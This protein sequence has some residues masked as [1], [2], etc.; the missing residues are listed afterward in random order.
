M[1]A[2]SLRTKI[3]LN[4]ILVFIVVLAL[5]FLVELFGIPFT[6]IDGEYQELTYAFLEN[7][8]L[9][10][11]LKKARLQE[12]LGERKGDLKVISES[13]ELKLGIGEIQRSV[14]KYKQQGWEEEQIWSTIQNNV[15]IQNL[16]QHLSL[17]INAYGFYERIHIID[18]GSRT[19]LASSDIDE[20]G[21]DVSHLDYIEPTLPFRDVFIHIEK[22]EA[23]GGVDL[24]MA[25]SVEIDDS[26][27]S[28]RDKLS[29]ILIMYI[30]SRN[31]IEPML[32]TGGGLGETG[33]V[34]LVNQEVKV[35]HR[36]K[37][38][39]ADGSAAE[40]LEFQIAAEPASFA[41]DGNEGIAMTED[42][43]QIPVL[44]AY[45]YIPLN[46]ESGWGLIVK[47]DRA[48]VFAPVYREINIRI[49]IAVLSLFVVVVMVWIFAAGLTKPLQILRKGVQS[50]E[51]GNFDV[52]IHIS[53]RTEIG[54]LAKTFN[55]MTQQLH[56]W[57]KELEAKV[58]A[59]TTKLA[60]ANRALKRVIKERENAEE[61]LLKNYNLLHTIIES[62][63]DAVYV[64]DMQ[65]RYIEANAALLKTFGKSREE[66]IGKDDAAILPPKTAESLMAV[67]LEVMET[68][69]AETYEEKT[70]VKGE[71]KA[72]LSNIVPYRD[73]VGNVIGVIG[74][75]KDI[76]ERKQVEIQTKEFSE[77][78]KTKVEER[79]QELA[80]KTQ[81]IEKT[82]Q[83][84][85]FLMEDVNEYRSEL[86]KANT[87]LK[88]ANQ[89]LESFSYSVSHDLRAPLRAI[90]GFSLKL[91]SNY[92]DVLDKE[93]RRLIN[94]VRNSTERMAQLID[95]LLAFSRLGKVPLRSQEFDMIRLSKEVT[96]E[97]IGLS[98]DRTIKIKIASLPPA[99]GDRNLIKQVLI[100]LVSNAIK[101]T[102][103]KSPAMIKIGCTSQENENIFYVKDNGVGFDMRY[104]G[105]L[106]HV[107]QRLHSETEFAGT[108]VGLAIV[109]RIIH[110]H[111]GKVWAEAELGKGATFYFSLEKKGE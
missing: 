45:R 9:V 42:Y 24:V 97:L 56:L 5:L 43:R 34:L 4:F 108:G 25:R 103:H 59:R 101:F 8:N 18:S 102:I 46:V 30:D 80:E 21:M 41:A 73:P 64:K 32:H 50:V 104:V 13:V 88:E 87:E 12:W 74:I 86:I 10:A 55:A 40:P 58:Q 66:V 29:L 69:A 28:E 62:T 89:E 20:L 72:W 106:F 54:Q 15:G 82:Q 48:E 49:V 17:I 39:L 75:S 71:T 83:A 93:G 14:Q 35:L 63:Q 96:Q 31:F 60:A 1:R 23:H 70:E 57:H 52:Q 110:R 84:L 38:P 61:S 111:G 53:D 51:K 81:S 37:H 33:E 85:S 105:K 65:G 99:V 2:V 11:D 100:N 68:G 76:T 47:K 78:L 90:D 16:H 26:F 67:D 79:T 36:L 44:A 27:R 7:L 22:D 107:F 77:V 3:T 91:E 109:H 95:D 94:I 98:P 19:V 6:N 92:S